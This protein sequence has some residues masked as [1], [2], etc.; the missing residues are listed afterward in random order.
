MAQPMLSTV[1]QAAGG[2][3]AENAPPGVAATGEAPK[4]KPVKERL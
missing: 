2:K 4:R 3:Q 1:L